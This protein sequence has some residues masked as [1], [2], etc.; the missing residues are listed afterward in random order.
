MRRHLIFL[1]TLSF[2]LL[3]LAPAMA[4]Q[5]GW[6]AKA[7]EE[8][9]DFS[10]DQLN[11]MAE[12]RSAHQKEMIPLRA[13]LRI[14]QIDFRE[15]MRK[16]ASQDAL[17]KKLEAIGD[18]KTKIR[19]LQVAHHLK[20]QAL[21]TPEQK[22]YLKEHPGCMHRM[23]GMDGGCG[24]GERM[25]DHFRGKMRGEGFECDGPWWD[26]SDDISEDKPMLGN[27]G[28]APGTC[29]KTCPHM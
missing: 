20:M 1:F 25:R 5:P 10:Q 23:G 22:Q 29:P 7:S 26:E 6:G 28:H 24:K 13:D 3:M 12:L 17:N 18:L 4:Q 16:E 27:C 19:K 8:F 21:M 2:A 9:P 15:L 11:K 14:L